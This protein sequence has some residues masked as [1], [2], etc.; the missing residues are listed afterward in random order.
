MSCD[1]HY[2]GGLTNTPDGYLD[3]APQSSSGILGDHVR[4]RRL[5]RIS[6]E[7]LDRILCSVL[8]DDAVTI[9]N[10]GNQTMSTDYQ[11]AIRCTAGLPADARVVRVNHESMFNTNETVLSVVSSVFD[12]VP[13]YHAT[14][15]MTCEFSVV[16]SLTRRPGVVGETHESDPEILGR[17]VVA[18]HTEVTREDLG[19]VIQAQDGTSIVRVLSRDQVAGLQAMVGAGNVPDSERS[20]NASA[21]LNKV[22][23]NRLR[24][25]AV[26]STTGSLTKIE[27]VAIAVLRGGDGDDAQ[28]LLDMAMDE[29]GHGSYRVPVRVVGSFKN[30]K[31]VIRPSEVPTSHE[32]ANVMRCCDEFLSTGGVS[33]MFLPAGWSVDIYEESSGEHNGNQTMT[34]ATVGE[35]ENALQPESSD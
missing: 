24:D 21:I 1:G 12:P 18:R 35:P 14:P 31:A 8:R 16:D 11:W 4:R 15:E 29:I 34:P 3:H 13:E 32:L 28:Y 22:P 26:R 20:A 30:C 2:V 25:L 27:E 10:H 5:V 23:R 19:E 9:F 6:N 33:A 17:T 7:L